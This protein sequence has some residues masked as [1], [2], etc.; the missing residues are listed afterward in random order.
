LMDQATVPFGCRG[1]GERPKLTPKYSCVR[2][3]SVAGGR[4]LAP[5]RASVPIAAP[6]PTQWRS[7]PLAPR[8][9]VSLQFSVP[10]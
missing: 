10:C 7:G 1:R 9:E 8:D 4:A 5:S 6:H 3:L 2:R